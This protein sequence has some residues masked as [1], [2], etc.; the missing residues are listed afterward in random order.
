[1]VSLALDVPTHLQN[2]IGGRRVWGL[3]S[4]VLGFGIRDLGSAIVFSGLRLNPYGF[5]FR[6]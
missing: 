5:G 4:G 1:M 2:I 6:V 3:R